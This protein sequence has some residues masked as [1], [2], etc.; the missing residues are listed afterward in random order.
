M[1]ARISNL[2]RILSKRKKDIV[3]VLIW[4]ALIALIVIRVYYETYTTSARLFYQKRA[5]PGYDALM[6]GVVDLI[7]MAAASIFVGLFVTDLKEM[8]YGYISAMLLAFF[9]SV[10]YALFYI[11]YILDLGPL[12]SVAPFEWEWA[13]LFAI[14][15]ILPIMFPWIIALCLIIVAVASFVREWILQGL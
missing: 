7:L 14:Y 5:F 1:E 8:F 12:F 10:V 11:W 13:V 2:F 9:V 15:G 4:A 6:P 3:L